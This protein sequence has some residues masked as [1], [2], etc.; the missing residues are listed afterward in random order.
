MP[1]VDGTASTEP[2]VIT[3]RGPQRSS[4][5][6]TGIPASAETTR[7]AENAAVAAVADQPVSAVIEAKATGKA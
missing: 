7:P 3:R 5:R 1:T 6:P 2:A 4:Q